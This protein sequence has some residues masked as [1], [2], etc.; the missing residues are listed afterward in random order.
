MLHGK[1]PAQGILLHIIVI[2]IIDL[3]IDDGLK[4]RVLRRIDAEPAGIKESCRLLP[5]VAEPLL[6]GLHDLL[7]ELIR[8]IGVGLRLILRHLHIDILNPLIDIVRHGLIVLLFGNIILL[9]HIGEHD[10]PALRV[11]LRVS[12]RVQAGRVF[13]DRRDDRALGERELGDLLI[14][15]MARRYLYAERVGA[16]IDRIQ[17]FRKDALLQAPLVHSRLRFELKREILLLELSDIALKSPLVE[18]SSKDI[19]L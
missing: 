1:T 8:K 14:E 2:R 10:R 15:I 9:Q 4:L 19:V 18:P 16:Q 5:A 7:R 17:I 3:L 13:R 6:E 12:D 11:V